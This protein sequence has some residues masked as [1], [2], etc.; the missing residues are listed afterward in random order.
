VTDR[1]QLLREL[2][3]AEREAPPDLAAEAR[4][5]AAIE[6]RLAQGPGP[7]NL[8]EP[9]VGGAALLKWV[10]GLALVGGLVGGGILLARSDPAPS[11]VAPAGMSA[12]TGR[13]ETG[14][15]DLSPGTAGSREADDLSPGTADKN[16]VPGT[17]QDLGP[18]DKNLVPGT[19][20]DPGP[21]DLSVGTGDEPRDPKPADLAAG[22]GG[23]DLSPGTAPRPARPNKARRKPSA[24]PAAPEPAEAAPAEPLD[25]AAEL[26]LLSSIRAALRRGDSDAALAGIAEHKQKFG[27]AGA[28]VQELRAHEVEALCAAGRAAEA[29]RLAD[30]FLRRYP[31]SPH[32]ARVAGECAE[33]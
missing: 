15:G 3:A 16:L 29:R 28:L 31:D 6:R 2:A 10:G 20:Q 4:N 22:T 19:G 33:K 7:P 23:P 5:W 13:S 12:A 27:A 11:P 9:G 17:G 8:P 25:L 32:R 21:A 18:A 30:E 26:R 1:Q 14:T 24:E